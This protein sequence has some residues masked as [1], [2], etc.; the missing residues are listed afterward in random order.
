MP[1]LPDRRV[2][3][4]V[5]LDNEA[6]QGLAD[7]KHPKHRTLL[8]HVAAVVVARKRGSGARLVVPT[9]VRVEAG[10]DRSTPRSAVI[11][12]LR[13][14]D[15]A[16]DAAAADVG[17]SIRRRTSVSVVDAHLGATVQ[18]LAADAVVVVLTSDPDDVLAASAPA[19]PRVVRI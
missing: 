5:I 16:L 2:P 12:Q 10:W 14:S 3:G 11:N 8:A 6:V 18:A 19:V 15:R 4:T 13:V 17:A 7:V 1:Q 9:S